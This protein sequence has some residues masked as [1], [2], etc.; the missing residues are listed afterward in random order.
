MADKIKAVL[1]IDL[2]VIGLWAHGPLR[3]GRAAAIF[4]DTAGSDSCQ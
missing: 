2:L 1:E 3:P 4:T